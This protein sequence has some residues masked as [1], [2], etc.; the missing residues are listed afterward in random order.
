M[1]ERLFRSVPQAGEQSQAWFTLRH[2]P[3]TV[4]SHVSQCSEKGRGR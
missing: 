4:S 2:F 3:S 1:I